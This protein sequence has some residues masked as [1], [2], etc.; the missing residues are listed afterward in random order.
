VFPNPNAIIKPGQFVKAR[1]TG[2][3][4]P[5]AIVVPQTAV[6]QGKKGMYVFIVTKENKAA[7]TY[8]E[9]GEWFAN[10]WIINGGLLP[11]DQVII[12]GVNK[13]QPGSDVIV[14]KKTEF[15][16]PD[17]KDQLTPTQSYGI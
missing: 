16:M 1:V 7:L 15:V 11:G 8:V 10:Y 12:S 4:R 9:P 13:V 3:F 6:L 5:N 2:A 17:Q 14:T